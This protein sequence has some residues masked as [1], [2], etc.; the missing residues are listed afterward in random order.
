VSTFAQVLDDTPA[1]RQELAMSQYGGYMNAEE[2]IRGQWASM[3]PELRAAVRKPENEEA[4][5]EL[6]ERG[7]KSLGIDVPEG[8]KLRAYKVR[9][10]DPTNLVIVY[11]WEDKGGSLHR[12]AQGYSDDYEAPEESP[13]DRAAREIAMHDARMTAEAAVSR[14]EV[15]KM[16]AEHQR[17]LEARQAE[18]FASLKDELV[19]TLKGLGGEGEAVK[20]T[21]AGGGEREVVDEGSGGEEGS[22]GGEGSS[23]SGT[24]DDDEP[25][26]PRT[27]ADLDALAE[28]EDVPEGWDDMKVD[29]KIDYLQS[30]G[31]RPQDEG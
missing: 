1:A 17:E 30:Q 6:S 21:E 3:S 31:I 13:G 23:G 9:G 14:D 24:S 20:G 10:S 4:T 28:G 2:L 15:A 29:E 18:H 26:Y 25:K 12:G 7:G 8:G 11:V 19:A 22:G 27:H 5:A 16:L